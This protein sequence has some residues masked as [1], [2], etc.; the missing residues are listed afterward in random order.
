MNHIDRIYFALRR[1]EE[2]SVVSFGYAGLV[3][4]G[5]G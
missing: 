3:S 2:K 4:D 5:T 1:I